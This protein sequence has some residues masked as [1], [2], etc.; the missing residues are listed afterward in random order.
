MREYRPKRPL[1]RLHRIDPYHYW[2][3]PNLLRDE[4]GRILSDNIIYVKQEAT[5]SPSLIKE[6]ERE[7]QKCNSNIEL[8]FHYISGNQWLFLLSSGVLNCKKLDQLQ[9]TYDKLVSLTN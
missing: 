4:S 8:A 3:Y 1:E 7:V 5:D 2:R 6:F 9:N